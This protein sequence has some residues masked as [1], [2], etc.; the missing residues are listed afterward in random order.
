MDIPANP[1]PDLVQV[2]YDAHTVL[3]D[4]IGAVRF[5]ARAPRSGPYDRGVCDLRRLRGRRGRCLPTP[6]RDD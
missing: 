5:I 4:E 2:I 3:A 6:P 1:A